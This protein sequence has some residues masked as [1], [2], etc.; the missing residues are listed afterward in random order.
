M[1]KPCRAQQGERGGASK[2]GVSVMQ[3]QSQNSSP[4]VV[5]QGPRFAPD[6]MPRPDQTCEWNM[7]MEARST[8]SRIS[9][10]AMGGNAVW[11]PRITHGGVEKKWRALAILPWVCAELTRHGGKQRYRSLLSHLT[12]LRPSNLRRAGFKYYR[13]NFDRSPSTTKST[14]AAPRQK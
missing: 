5:L 4:S 14:K 7:P 8:S 2:D 6:A 13:P 10:I 1:A 12:L 9:S 11:G 3:Q